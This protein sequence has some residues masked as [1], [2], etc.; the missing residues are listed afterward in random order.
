[1]AA[2]CFVVVPAS[3]APALDYHGGVTDELAPGTILS[4][5]YEIVRRLGA[6]GMGAVYEAKHLRLASRRVAVKV[7]LREAADDTELF[8][9]FR[10]E[11]EIGAR[12]G[13]PNIVAVTDWDRLPGGEPFLVMELL[14]GEDLH[15]RMA[16]GRLP[17]ALIYRIVREVGSALGAAHRQ[18]IVHRDLKPQN[19]FLV[20]VEEA[21]GTVLHAKVLDFGISKIAASQSLLTKDLSVI[22]TPRYMAP[23]QALGRHG[24]LDGRADQFAL[25]TV[26]YELLAGSVAFEGDSAMAVLYKVINEPPRPLAEVAPS[27]PAAVARAVERGMAKAKEERFPDVAA[28]VTAVLEGA[29]LGDGEAMA[30]RTKATSKRGVVWALGGAALLAAAGLGAVQVLHRG[31][32][33][34]TGVHDA[35]VPHANVAPPAVHIPTPPS[36]P[37]ISA[38]SPAQPPTTAN[39]AS[40]AHEIAAPPSA[41][42]VTA[43]DT[44][45]ARKP[46]AARVAEPPAVAAELDEAERL[47]HGANYGDAV[48]RARQ[49]LGV[50]ATPRAHRIIVLGYCGLSDLGNARAALYSVAGSDRRQVVERCL[51][52]GVDLR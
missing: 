20:P 50:K 10:R 37:P 40:I 22:G 9:R 39:D 31:S 7:L 14:A 44:Q 8:A 28:F 21:T 47:L 45:P 27:V 36:T 41:T 33:V 49:T 17:D 35:S 48:H 2:R 30:A 52:L 51:R 15:A 29:G 23:E 38:D 43:R 32:V 6:G 3:R 11:A 24:E 25:A 5:T 26:L 34:S 12:L 18:G 1:M 4:E 42:A 19:I 13:H 16:R 46:P